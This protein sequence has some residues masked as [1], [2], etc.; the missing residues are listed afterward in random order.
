M[1]LGMSLEE[2]LDMAVI[3]DEE[4]PPE[5]LAPEEILRSRC[6]EIFQKGVKLLKERDFLLAAAHF[7]AVSIICPDHVKTWNNLGIAYFHLGRVSQA[8]EAFEKALSLE[9]ENTLAKENLSLLNKISQGGGQ[10]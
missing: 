7:L 5:G 2:L 8:K 4:H 10:K 1:S 9:P 3:T 6:E